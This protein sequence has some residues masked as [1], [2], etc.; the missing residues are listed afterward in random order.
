MLYFWYSERYSR[1][2]KFIICIVVCSIILLSSQDFKLST[3][4]IVIALG[5]GAFYHLKQKIKNKLQTNHP[6]KQGF[7]ILLFV[8]PLIIFI[9]LIIS[10]P[11]TGHLYLSI[12]TLGYMLIG[13]FLVSI[14]SQRSKRFD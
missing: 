10:L 1:S 2:M 5:L 3:P 7:D 4:Y 6:Y 9:G 12:Q 14:Y 8:F 11:R 13:F